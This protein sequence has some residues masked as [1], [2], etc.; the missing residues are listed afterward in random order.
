MLTLVDLSSLALLCGAGFLA[1]TV[2]GFSGFGSAIVFLPVAAQALPPFQALTTV[3]IADLLGALPNAPRALRA[4]DKGDLFRLLVGLAVA[5]PLGLWA[6]TLLEPE[7][8]RYGVS[9]LALALLLCLLLGVRYRGP[10][11][12]AMVYG[13][14]GLSGFSCGLAGL[15]GP[16]VILFYMARPL[17]PAAI[18]AN[19]FIFLTSADIAMLPALYALGHFDPDAALLG[20]LLIAPTMAGNLFGAWLFRPDYERLYRFVAYAVIGTIALVSLPFWRA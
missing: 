10:T 12:N 16:P 7:T 2:R 8:F 14:G 4:C 18:R 15:P 6:L 11:P 5:L 17:P 19:T 13:V 20:C 3:V 1:G 9:A